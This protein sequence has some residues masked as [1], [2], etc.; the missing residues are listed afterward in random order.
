[1]IIC[2]ATPGNKLLCLMSYV[3]YHEFLQIYWR[4]VTWVLGKFDDHPMF[5]PL[6]SATVWLPVRPPLPGSGWIYI[7][8]CC[9]IL[10]NKSNMAI[11]CSIGS[12]VDPDPAFFVNGDPDADPDAD[13]DP[14]PGF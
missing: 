13:P 11:S 12:V 5:R 9:D 3:L 1:M 10:I 8:L 14:D 6:P 4:S 7:F 2:I